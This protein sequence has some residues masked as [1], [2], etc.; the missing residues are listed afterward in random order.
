MKTNRILNLIRELI[1]ISAEKEADNRR[2]N[3]EERV[4]YFQG[5]RHGLEDLRD[6][7]KAYQKLKGNR[8][9]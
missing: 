4:V 8:N 5:K 6:D 7:I 9:K 3:D 2:V 1:V